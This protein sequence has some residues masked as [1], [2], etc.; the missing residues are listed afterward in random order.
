VPEKTDAVPNDPDDLAQAGLPPPE[1]PAGR[2]Q[3]VTDDLPA[4]GRSEAAAAAGAHRKELGKPAFQDPTREF[5][6]PAAPP[7]SASSRSGPEAWGDAPTGDLPDAPPRKPTGAPETT[8]F[9]HHPGVSAAWKR[10]TRELWHTLLE[11]QKL[12]PPPLPSWDPRAL[13]GGV[14]AVLLI[15]LGLIWGALTGHEPPPP[16][17][18]AAVEAAPAPETKAPA[19]PHKRPGKKGPNRKR[20]R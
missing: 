4:P 17:P 11:Q 12:L 19:H 1:A 14:G 7:A 20:G 9:P 2:S 13:W 15:V 18:P 10:L 3:E 8:F 16:A 6:R 5:E